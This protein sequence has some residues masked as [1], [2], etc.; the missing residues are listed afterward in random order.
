MIQITNLY[1]IV[2]IMHYVIVP[3]LQHETK[4]T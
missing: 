1:L 3:E 2:K 4:W